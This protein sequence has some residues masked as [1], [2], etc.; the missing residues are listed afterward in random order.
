MIRDLILYLLAMTL[1]AMGYVAI[2]QREQYLNE[3]RM[4]DVLRQQVMQQDA[5]LAKQALQIKKS[6]RPRR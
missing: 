4:N 2:D 1:I 5:L 6:P 3:R